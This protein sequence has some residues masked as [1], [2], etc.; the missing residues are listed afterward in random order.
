VN[1][2]APNANRNALKRPRCNS[3]SFQMSKINIKKRLSGVYPTKNALLKK[4]IPIAP[5]T[6]TNNRRK[7]DNRNDHLGRK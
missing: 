6:C 2:P 4:A 7:T 5:E 3:V 1:S